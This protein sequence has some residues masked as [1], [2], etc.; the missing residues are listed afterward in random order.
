MRLFVSGGLVAAA[1][2]MTAGS[3]PADEGSPAPAGVEVGLRTGYALPFGGISGAS[4]GVNAISLSNSV[5]G[6]LPLWLDAGYRFSPNVYIGAFFQYGIGFVNS[7]NSV[8]GQAGA[9]CSAND[10]QFGANFHYHLSPT[11]K[12]DPWGG[13]GVGY[14]ILNLGTTVQGMSA[15]GNYQGF[16]FF[17]LQVGGNYN[18]LPN[19]GV[20]PFLMFSLGEYF[21]CSVQNPCSVHNAVLHEWL[22]IGIRG[23]FDIDLGGSSS[24]PPSP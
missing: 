7:G 24:P 5:S 20:G 3:A 2:V 13:I 11:K 1:I 19:L 22:T 12:V 18:V 23:A 14:E 10:I 4:S 6:V 15:S 17:N 8:C 9:S 21:Q 16:Q